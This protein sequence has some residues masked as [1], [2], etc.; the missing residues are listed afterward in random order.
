MFPTSAR[1]IPIGKFEYFPPLVPIDFYF[2]L[3]WINCSYYED[4]LYDRRSIQRSLSQ[5]SLA[6]SATEFTERWVIP[7]DVSDDSAP[8]RPS[9]NTSRLVSNPH[10]LASISNPNII[11]FIFYPFSRRLHSVRGHNTPITSSRKRNTFNKVRQHSRQQ[12]PLHRQK[13]GTPILENKHEKFRK[14]FSVRSS[15]FIDSSWKLRSDESTFA[16]PF[17]L[18]EKDKNQKRNCHFAWK[19]PKMSAGP[20]HKWKTK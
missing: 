19:Y 10:S 4:D 12:T 3:N 15:G 18:K 1:F 17:H 11:G 16:I 6:R 7:D 13:I 20:Q 8:E 2:L 5:P 14:L 9:R